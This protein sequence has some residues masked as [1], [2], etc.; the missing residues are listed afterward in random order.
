MSFNTQK[1]LIDDITEDYH[2]TI[3]KI[4][5]DI[6]R[7]NPDVLKYR[8]NNINNILYQLQEEVYNLKFQ[9]NNNI[10]LSPKELEDIQVNRRADQIINNLCLPLVALCLSSSIN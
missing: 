9:L 4:P 6:F 1:A 10:Y 5:P 2:K 3:N 8:I 7:D